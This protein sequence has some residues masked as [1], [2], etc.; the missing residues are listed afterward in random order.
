MAVY[1]KTSPYYTTTVFDKYLDVMTNRDIP[2]DST[3]SIVVISSAYHQR[4]DLLA[5]DLYDDARLWW[6]F[7]IRNPNTLEDPVFDFLSGTAIYVP[8]RQVVNNALGL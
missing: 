4:P 7:A 2:V 6:V 8:T 1:S 3:D 5:Y